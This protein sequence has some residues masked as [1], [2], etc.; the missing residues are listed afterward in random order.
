[1]TKTKSG[2]GKDK[3]GT[4]ELNYATTNEKEMATGRICLSFSYTE[5]ECNKSIF[6]LCFFRNGVDKDP[7]C[8]LGC[9]YAEHSVGHYHNEF[10]F[11][12]H[13]T[14]PYRDSGQTADFS[15]SH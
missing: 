14:K 5:N 11:N 3:N 9:C 4:Q 7:V 10:I 1:M 13:F 2:M 8:C 6:I 15:K 12:K